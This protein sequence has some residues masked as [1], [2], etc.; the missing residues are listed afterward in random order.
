VREVEEQIFLRRFTADCMTHA[1]RCVDEGGQPRLD[2]CCQH[3][4]DVDLFEKDAILAR[5]A[6]IAP[7]LEARFR[8]PATWFDESDPDHDPEYP[9]GTAIRTGRAAPDE[10]SGCVFLQ[11]DQ[12]GC[13]LHRAALAS[14]FAPEEI[15]PAVCRLYP[16]AFGEGIL[17]LSDDFD[18]YSCADDGSGPTVYRLM[19]QV[20]GEI[21]GLGVVRQ[22]DALERRVLGRRL[23][24]AARIGP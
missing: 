13:A 5:A 24:L 14:G 23:P 2:A 16:L 1:C 12:R 11:H 17:G 9:S 18:R 19:R 15:K 8:D 20:V 10:S 6:E 7:L 21:F 22:L 4:A 3:G